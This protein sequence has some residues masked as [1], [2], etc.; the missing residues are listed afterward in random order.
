MKSSKILKKGSKVFIPD[1]IR[2]RF[3][4]GAVG[5][6]KKGEVVRVVEKQSCVYVEVGDNILWYDISELEVI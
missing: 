4:S 3:S 6:G 5:A 2:Y 1:I